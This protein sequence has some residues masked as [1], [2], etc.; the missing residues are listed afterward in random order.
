MEKKSSGLKKE[1][2]IQ[3][4]K[5]RG[6]RLTDKGIEALNTVIDMIGTQAAAA[7]AFKMTPTL[8]SLVLARKRTLSLDIIKNVV[9]ASR[10]LYTEGVFIQSEDDIKHATLDSLIKSLSIDLVDKSDE[11]NY[12]DFLFKMSGS[13]LQY[14]HYGQLREEDKP[15]FSILFDCDKKI[16]NINK[17]NKSKK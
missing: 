17:N 11:A 7:S 15:Y 9:E 12:R 3:G 2:P 1:K 5:K 13:I 16:F 10:G 14:L 8:L 4:R 6:Y